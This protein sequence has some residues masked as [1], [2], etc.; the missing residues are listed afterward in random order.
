MIA[1]LRRAAAADHGFTLLELSVAAFLSTMV[2][3]AVVL[4]FS[5]VSRGAS[6]AGERC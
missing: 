1:R 3:G 5:S 6:D 2:L 4:I